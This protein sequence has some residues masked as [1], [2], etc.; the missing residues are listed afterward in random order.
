MDER[1]TRIRQT[2]V[3]AGFVLDGVRKLPEI[4]AVLYQMYYG[5][6]GAKG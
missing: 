5:K 1:E 3:E 4:N 2:A 6:N